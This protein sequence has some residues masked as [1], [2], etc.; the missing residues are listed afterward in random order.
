MCARRSEDENASARTYAG[1]DKNAATPMWDNARR[2]SSKSFDPLDTN[3]GRE[4]GGG[5][6]PALASRDFAKLE[7]R[8]ATKRFFFISFGRDLLVGFDERVSIARGLVV[9][10]HSPCLPSTW[11]YCGAAVRRG[12]SRESRWRLPTT[13]DDNART[14]IGSRFSCEHTF[15][16]RLRGRAGG[17]P[18]LSYPRLARRAT[19]YWIIRRES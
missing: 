19:P 7:C 14:R 17:L 2:V 6:S 4:N 18:S 12:R 10:Y 5:V 9:I 15:P 3:A 11:R 1:Q 13:A 8:N 16:R